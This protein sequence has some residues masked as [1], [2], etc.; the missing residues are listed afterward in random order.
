MTTEVKVVFQPT[1]RAV[2]VLPGTVILEAAGRAGIILQTPCGGRGTCGKCRVKI[3]GDTGSVRAEKPACLSQEEFDQ[4]YRLACQTNIDGPTV[5]DVP[6]ASMFEHSQRI[7]VGD[8]GEKTE[9]NPVIRK[10]Y[11][12]LDPPS[13][14]DLRSDQT[15]LLDVIGVDVRMSAD[16]TAMLPTF[17]RAENWCGTAVLSDHHLIGLE[18][19]DTTRETYGIAVDA[20]TTTVVGT[21]FDLATGRELSVASRMNGQIAYGDDVISRIGRVRE[22]AQALTMLQQA[23]VETLNTII[24]EATEQAGVSAGRVYEISVAGNSTMQ[25]ILCGFDP[26]ALGE[27]PFV[28]VFDKAQT[29]SAARLGITAGPDAEVYVF[30]QIGGF[31]GGDTVAGMVASRLDRWETPVLLV[32]IGTNG[33]IVLAHEGKMY[34]T[35]TAAG[36]AFEG[37]RI[38]Q[39]MRATSGAIEKVLIDDDVLYN[40]IGNTR[41]AGIC[42]TALIDT[43]AWMMR[44]GILDETGRILGEDELPDLPDALRKRLVVMDDEVNFLLVPPEE[45]AGGRPVYLWQR[46]IRELQLATAAIRAGI[47]ILLRRAGLAP[48]DLG[49]VLL[50]GAFGNFIRR[51][52]ARR[53]GLLPQIACSQIRFIGNA[54][55]MG[56]K[57]VLLSA[58]ERKLADDMRRRTEHVDLSQDTDFLSE[59]SNAMLFPE[60]DLDVCS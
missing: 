19:G 11:F 55:S 34:A 52:N 44:K 10:V 47:Q 40:V 27:L 23:M 58:D 45:S 33:E 38:R 2:Y 56:A 60:D 22:N 57:M 26:S 8:S 16:F 12:K 53:I 1:G 50:A 46:D 51:N 6:E 28:Q 20:G 54:A 30:P 42:G 3:V 37:A 9:F 5:V 13:R 14:E 49:A 59:F 7:L 18:K 43:A 31:V 39:G 25:Q 35:S 32:D 41:P 15:R 48:K 36:P 17:L 4:G 21:L 29:L 24:R